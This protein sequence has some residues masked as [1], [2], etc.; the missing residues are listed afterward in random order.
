MIKYIL[1]I[2]L[3][4][5]SCTETK[6]Q[7]KILTLVRSSM[8]GH[9][10]VIIKFSLIKNSLKTNNVEV[11]SFESSQPIRLS[12]TNNLNW[13]YETSKRTD[14]L[15]DTTFSFKFYYDLETESDNS[16]CDYYILTGD[17]LM[18]L[19]N[20]FID[21]DRNQEL[22]KFIKKISEIEH[23]NLN[24]L[25]KG[26]LLDIDE[27]CQIRSMNHIINDSVFNLDYKN[28]L[29]KKINCAHSR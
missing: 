23:V 10:P 2:L 18:K 5:F 11:T 3:C 4:I 26:S 24:F 27:L 12:T 29:G 21:D 9:N 6:E 15:I 8:L 16:Y 22:L 20:S 14:Y 13:F 1:F 17:S 25:E 28:K 7:E 19:D